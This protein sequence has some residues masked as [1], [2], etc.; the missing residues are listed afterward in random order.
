MKTKTLCVYLACA[1]GACALS[2]CGRKESK[3][4]LIP[5]AS[6][7]CREER[8][9]GTT[10]DAPRQSVICATQEISLVAVPATNIRI[11]ASMLIS[12]LFRAEPDMARFVGD[13]IKQHVI[14]FVF[15]ARSNC[16]PAELYEICVENSRYTNDAQRTRA[17]A[18]GYA[19]RTL[20]YRCLVPKLKEL[21]LSQSVTNDEYAGSMAA[22]ALR[23]IAHPDSLRAC[24]EISQKL[25]SNSLLRVDRDPHSQAVWRDTIPFFM[26]PDCLPIYLEIVNHSRKYSFAHWWGTVEKIEAFTN[27]SAVAGLRFA[28]QVVKNPAPYWPD[29]T[30]S[31]YIVMVEMKMKHQRDYAKGKLNMERPEIPVFDE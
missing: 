1:A 29:M 19:Y 2:T 6:Q 23:I 11:T 12:N 25:P 7:T 9:A 28:L 30:P 18:F 26:R 8:V 20:R 17:R 15:V 4:H 27:E 10:A 31:L 21:I 13:D 24:I 22:N 5:Q 14:P 3:Q 16:T